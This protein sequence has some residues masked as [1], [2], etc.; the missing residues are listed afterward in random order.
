MICE[1]IS[2]KPDKYTVHHPVKIIYCILFTVQSS[3]VWR[4]LHSTEKKNCIVFS[5]M[6]ISRLEH[7]H[8]NI[9]FYITMNGLKAKI[10]A[11]KYVKERK[12][13]RQLI[14]GNEYRCDD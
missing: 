7:F 1:W 4:I 13:P 8:L 12:W 2:V 3:D 6:A 5:E 10:N 9:D 14:N 11:K